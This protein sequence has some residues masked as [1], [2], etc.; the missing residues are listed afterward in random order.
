MDKVFISQ[1]HVDTII[2]VYDF[3]KET[4]QSLFF[5]IEMLTDIRAAANS[6]DI[7]DTVDYAVVSERIIKYVTAKPVDLLETLVEQI[8]EFI[9][10]DFNV[11][12]VKVRVSKPAAVKEANTVGVE[13][14]RAVNNTRN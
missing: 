9:L 4:K 13:I 11:S 6:D 10:S 5:D 12:E 7:N 14:I 3:E 2:G 8:A 1:L